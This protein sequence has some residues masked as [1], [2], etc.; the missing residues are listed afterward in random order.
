MEGGS[1]DD[2][3]R[4]F[5]RLPE[6]LAKVY[7]AQVCVCARTRAHSVTA[8][9]IDCRAQVL[10]GLAYLHTQGV[11]HRDVKA[12]NCLCDKA[13]RVKLADFGVWVACAS[14]RVYKCVSSVDG[15]HR[16]FN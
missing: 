13:G 7:V 5:G 6:T 9:P 16:H 12:G 3:I 8:R 2:L 4:Q 14:G 15:A 1:L 10:E 11:V